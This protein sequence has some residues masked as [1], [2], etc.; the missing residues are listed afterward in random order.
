MTLL[1]FKSKFKPT[2]IEV[3]GQAFYVSV[4]SA[5]EKDRFD[6]QYAAF[7]GDGGGVGL[8][9]FLTAFC[10]CDK[11]GKKDFSSGDDKTP[12]KE[13]L[14]AVNTIGGLPITVVDPIFE[15]ACEVNGFSLND[16][17]SAKNSE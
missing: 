3:E 1:D 17:G 10:L 12:S 14:D 15:A 4:L 13:F 8:R 5:L 11:D 9:G 7:R 16:E 2:K 6:L